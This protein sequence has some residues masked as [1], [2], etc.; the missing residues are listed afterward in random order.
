[1]MLTT[2]QV[3]KM[4]LSFQT[5]KDMRSRIESLPPGPQWKAIPWK[6]SHPTKTPLTLFY[7]DPLECLQ[8]LLSNPLVQDFIEYTPFR[9]WDSSAKLMRKYSEWLSGDAAWNI[10]V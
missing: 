5:A 8:A 2:F 1:M 7:R 6:P 10:Q 3:Q 4:N 9:L